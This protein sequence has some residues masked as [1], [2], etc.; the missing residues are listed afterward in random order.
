[1]HPGSQLHILGVKGIV[2]EGLRRI[3]AIP[4]RDARSHARGRQAIGFQARLAFIGRGGIK[5]QTQKQARFVFFREGDAVGKRHVRVIAARQE[6]LPAVGGEQRRQP[7]GPIEREFPL[8][9]VA[10]DALG[11][12][13]L[14]AVPR[15]NDDRWVGSEEAHGRAADQGPEGLLQIEGMNERLPVNHMRREPQ[16]QFHPVPIRQSQAGPQDKNAV[17][18]AERVA[19]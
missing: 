19:R 13:V 14:A 8:V 15:V 5:V 2:R 11:A 6:Y 1:M 17:S 7:P 9:A 12:G 18:R 3:V 4:A 10:Q 16:P